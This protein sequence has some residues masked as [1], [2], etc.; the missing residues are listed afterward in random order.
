MQQPSRSASRRRIAIVTALVGL[1]SLLVVACTPP[2]APLPAANY[3]TIRDTWALSAG[4]GS[5]SAALGVL[6]NSAGRDITVI[7]ATSDI[8]PSM[9]LHE[10]VPNGSGGTTMQPKAGGFK[11]PAGG[12]Y[13][14]Q[15]GGDHL[16]L[17]RL[18]RTLRAGETVTV[19]LT[20]DDG[21]TKQFTA[22]ARNF[23]WPM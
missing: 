20:F 6:E 1:G 8:S 16:M 21:S 14:L 12:E 9:E 23:T 13:V 18:T 7:A 17:M 5:M 3:V 19:T 2:P 10:T 22:T 11:I 4:S 15:P